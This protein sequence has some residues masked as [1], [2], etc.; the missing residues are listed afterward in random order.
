MCSSDLRRIQQL[1]GGQPLPSLKNKIVI[2]ADDGIATGSTLFAAIELCKKQHPQKLI[3]AAP[4]AGGEI[5]L[6]LKNLVDEVVILDTPPGFYAVSQGYASFPQLSDE[7]ARSFF[8]K[9]NKAS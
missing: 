4:V 2:L 3:V 9:A 6:R 1:R 8:E 5:R 7:E